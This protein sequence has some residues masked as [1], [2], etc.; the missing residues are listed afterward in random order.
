MR[1]TFAR[2]CISLLLGPLLAALLVGTAA[3][4]AGPARA[5]D[6]STSSGSSSS[7][8]TPPVIN[9]TIKASGSGSLPVGNTRV[10]TAAVTVDGKEDASTS[11]AWES[12]NPNVAT[13]ENGTVTAVELGEATITVK[14]SYNKGGI[15]Y[16]RSATYAVKV[17]TASVK[18][19]ALTI[20]GKDGSAPDEIVQK[21]TSVGDSVAARVEVAPV[22]SDTPADGTERPFTEGEEKKL[23]WSARII[24]GSQFISLPYEKGK[25]IPSVPVRGLK[26]TGTNEKAVV[27]VEVTYYNV[28]LGVGGGGEHPL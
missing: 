5:G 7:S 4:A 3:L 19:L 11:L 12:S 24:Q 8:T 10:L 15:S 6:A 17:V 14:A 25:G 26:P 21:K 20:D 9:V 13:V 16:S 22:W 1:K 2:Y 28:G 23:E 27:E 18:S